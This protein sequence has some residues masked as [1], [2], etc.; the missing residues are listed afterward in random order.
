MLLTTLPPVMITC[1]FA[2]HLFYKLFPAK[3]ASDLQR[4]QYP[5]YNTQP[6]ALPGQG[7]HANWRKL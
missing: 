2:T 6:I 3:T 1:L 4:G 7:E 5:L